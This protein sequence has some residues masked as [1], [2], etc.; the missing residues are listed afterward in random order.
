MDV[1]GLLSEI[2]ETRFFHMTRR[3]LLY[4][5]S[6]LNFKSVFQLNSQTFTITGCQLHKDYPGN[7]RLSTNGDN[8]ILFLDRKIGL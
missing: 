4:L 2:F 6:F 3:S 5:E 7:F 1:K 8:N